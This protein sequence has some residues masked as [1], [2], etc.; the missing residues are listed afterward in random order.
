MTNISNV[1]AFINMVNFATIVQ[2]CEEFD[3]SESTARRMLTTLAQQ[4][5]IQRFHGGAI[6]LNRYDTNTNVGKRSLERHK[7]KREIARK[8]CDIIQQNSTIILL[9]G[10]TVC[11][12][13]HFIEN[14]SLTVITNSLLVLNALQY[15][16][17]VRIIFLGGLFNLQEFEVGG[18][19][20]NLGL[21][22]IRADYLFMG[23]AA[24]D[25]KHGFT[26]ADPAIELYFSCLEASEVACVLADSSK[27]MNGGT[28]VT[29]RPN[30]IKYLFTDSG[31]PAPVINCFES[32]GTKVILADIPNALQLRL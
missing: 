31:L 10:S 12:M 14:T 32:Y 30:Q 20:A 29:A 1:L 4:G 15:S 11:E 18:I 2:I 28:S 23:T 7:I 27:Y 17:T 8:A 13:C 9:G 19:L 25:E 24:F 5:L 26:T 16:P 3:I 6:S 21:K 22:H